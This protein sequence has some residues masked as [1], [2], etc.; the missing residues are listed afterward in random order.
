MRNQAKALAF[1]WLLNEA[2]ER[3]FLEV[4][5]EEIFLQEQPNLCFYIPNA[6]LA[7]NSTGGRICFL[8]RTSLVRAPNNTLE[9]K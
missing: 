1:I 7:T 8:E 6:A 5:R 3:S 9:T 4:K 2:L